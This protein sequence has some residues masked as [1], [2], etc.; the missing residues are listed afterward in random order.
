[1]RVENSFIPVSG[2][3][4]TTERRLW[5]SGVTDWHGYG[6][7]KPRGVG[8]TT[9]NRIEAFVDEA[10]ER[11]DDGDASYFDRALPDDEHWRLYENFRDSACFFDIETTGLSQHRDRVTTV[12]FH[13]DGETTTLVQGRD[14]TR[15]NVRQQFDAAD[16]LLTFNGKRFDVP[17]LETSFDLGVETPH[18]D[19]MYPCKKVGLTGGLKPIEE[20]LGIAR[21]GPDISGRD[22]VRLWHEYEAGDESSLE[23]LVSYNRDDTVNL[24]RLADETCRRLHHRTPLDD[25]VSDLH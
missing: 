14:L 15:E 4:Q 11:L 25:A 21:D 12:S 6:G 22:A 13:R 1:M 18:L 8:A 2:V 5:E 20:E 24:K 10:L 17:F 16:L 7:E 9:A 19:L 23:K 3:G